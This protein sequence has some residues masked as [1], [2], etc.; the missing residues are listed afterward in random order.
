MFVRLERCLS[1]AGSLSSYKHFCGR[2]RN[3]RTPDF[4]EAVIQRFEE[5][6][7][8]S[9]RNSAHTL[10]VNHMSVWQ[11]LHDAHFHT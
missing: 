6:P 11:V 7:D 10:V 2:Q 4:E 3:R 8:T 5:H 1:E 9:T